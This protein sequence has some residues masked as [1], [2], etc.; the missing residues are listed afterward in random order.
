MRL[1]S[2]QCIGHVAFHFHEW[3]RQI[4]RQPF[5]LQWHHFYSDWLNILF[6]PPSPHPNSSPLVEEPFPATELHPQAYRIGFLCLWHHNPGCLSLLLSDCHLLTA[7]L[8]HHHTRHTTRV[9]VH[10]IWT[11][12]TM[13]N[14]RIFDFHPNE[15]KNPTFSHFGI[16]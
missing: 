5:S 16:I 4:N 13:F 2:D 15:N 6:A 12:R 1:G 9:K 11:T 8:M 14:N 7:V 3:K 10:Q